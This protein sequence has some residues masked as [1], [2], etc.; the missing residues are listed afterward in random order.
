MPPPG[1]DGD[2]DEDEDEDEDEDG[3]LDSKR[4]KLILGTNKPLNTR[5]HFINHVC[6]HIM[7]FLQ[8]TKSTIHSFKVGGLLRQV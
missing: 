8:H 3:E 2:G 5:T 1:G 7:F 6:Q 4:Q